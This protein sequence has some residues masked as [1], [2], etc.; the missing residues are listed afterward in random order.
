MQRIQRF[1][2]ESH[3]AP[4]RRG[5]FTHISF[6]EEFTLWTEYP[7][8]NHDDGKQRHSNQKFAL[9]AAFSEVRQLDGCIASGRK[10]AAADAASTSAIIQFV[11]IR[12]GY[13]TFSDV[14]I[15]PDSWLPPPFNGA[16]F[17]FL[18]KCGSQFVF[19]LCFK[20]T[21]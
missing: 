16:Q 10:M 19:Q 1:A 13:L 12:F 14:G 11:G 8:K 18:L 3:T 9:H 5:A 6:S 20:G 15:V 17:V 21:R 7:G 2:H 4:E